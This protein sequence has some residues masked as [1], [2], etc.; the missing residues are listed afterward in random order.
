MKLIKKIISLV[1]VG[2]FSMQLVACSMFQ[3]TFPQLDEIDSIL[4]EQSNVLQENADTEGN[5]NQ[6]MNSDIEMS[7]NLF[8]FTIKLD[9]TVLQL[10]CSSQELMDA[11]WDF[12][13]ADKN[14]M[15]AGESYVHVYMNKGNKQILVYFYNMS[16]NACEITN[17]K[18][19]GV[20]I[21]VSDDISFELSKGIN[22]ESQID[23][24]IAAYGVPSERSTYDDFEI[25]DYRDNDSFYNRVKFTYYTEDEKKLYSSIE[26][27]NFVETASDK[28][29]TNTQ[30]PVYLD[31]YVR[32]TALGTDLISGNISIEGDVY[33]LPTPVS[34][35]M[36]RGWTIV[37]QPGGISSGNNDY[38]RLQKNDKEL[39]V[40]VTNYAEYQTTAENCVVFSLYVNKDYSEID[41]KIPNISFDSTKEDVEKYVTD[42]FYRSENTDKYSY[43]YSEYKDRDFSLSISVDKETGKVS[44]ISIKDE[45]WDY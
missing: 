45:T 1:L 19:G 6:N 8:D 30:R 18:V 44:Y 31:D 21:E 17:C 5:I 11:G 22:L 33:H 10:P 15:V 43:Q 23:E 36:D 16:G 28:T 41:L 7:E 4:N 27:K 14:S 3:N 12:Y 37:Q 2:V 13:D 42:E 32:P 20:S 25:L 29:E 39:D 35:F 38:I 34:E 26:I 9:G 40:R 24:I